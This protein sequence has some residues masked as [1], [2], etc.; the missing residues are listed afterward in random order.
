MEKWTAD[1]SHS[2]ATL[3]LAVVAGVAS[4]ILINNISRS[5]GVWGGNGVYF[6]ALLVFLLLGWFVAYHIPVYATLAG[7]IAFGSIAVGVVVDVALDW[8][9]RAYDRNLWP[10]EIVM[11][12]A[13]APVPMI[14]GA[15]V[16]R[17]FATRKEQRNRDREGNHSP[18]S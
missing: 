15:I 7:F 17:L 10:F 12:W 11:W 4:P 14:L 6:V 16:G 5:L 2:T 13:F 1:R 8:F 3:W 18:L 9:L